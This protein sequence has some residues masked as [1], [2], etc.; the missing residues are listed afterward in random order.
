MS[1]QRTRWSAGS[2]EEAGGDGLRCAAEGQAQAGKQNQ[3]HTWE[4]CRVTAG[5]SLYKKLR[6][7]GREGTEVSKQGGNTG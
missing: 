1:K 7:T 3:G 5:V 4:H 2:G 6:G